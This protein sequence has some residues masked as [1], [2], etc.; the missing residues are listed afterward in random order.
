MTNVLRTIA[1][2]VVATACGQVLFEPSDGGNLGPGQQGSID[3]GLPRDAELPD[4]AALA[5]AD[6]TSGSDA[7]APNEAV[8]AAVGTPSSDAA[9]MSPSPD[10]AVVATNRGQ[11][12]DDFAKCQTPL[13]SGWLF[14]T[15]SR[16]F[17]V[18][19]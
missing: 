7:T 12:G 16:R 18:A 4:A 1:I 11:L 13:K 8:D 2:A 6:A 10:G 19:N 17:V 14:H 9:M 5:G 15:V 3:A